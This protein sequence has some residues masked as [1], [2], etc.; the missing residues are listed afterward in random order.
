MI[1]LKLV[2][3]LLSLSII[4][5]SIKKPQISAAIYIIY[6]FLAP[7]MYINGF[8]IYERVGAIFFLTMFL[9][10]FSKKIAF[11]DYKPFIPFFFLLFCQLISVIFAE[12]IENSFSNWLFGVLNMCF[13]LFL[14]GNIKITP[15]Y[16][17]VYKWI[18]FFTMLLVTI[19]GL[20]LT[21][22]PGVNP[23]K[24]IEQPL[25]GQEFNEAY[26][27]GG[28]GNSTALIQTLRDGRLFGRISSFFD[29]PMTYGLHLGLFFIF[30]LYLFKNRIKI[31]I[32]ILLLIITAILTSGVR[33]PIAALLVTM[34]FV[35]LYMKK[36]SYFVFG[37]F[38]II[39]LLYIVPFISPEMGEYVSSIINSDNSEINGS[40]TTMRLEQL[41]GCWNI[42]QE[43]TQTLIMGKGL[44]WTVWYNAVKGSHP[45]ALYFESLIFVILVETGILG[46]VSWIIFT[47]KYYN[48]SIQFNDR[49]KKMS[50]LSLLVYFYV[51]C[52][53][54]G[55]FDIKNIFIY[56]VIIMFM[57]PL[58]KKA[59]QQ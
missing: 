41:E 53:I 52:V 35:V 3:T 18:L 45:T 50:I 8:I 59:F 36:M 2:L 4:G 17:H 39:I 12:K 7:Y 47:K 37:L 1:I 57:S 46:C 9:I 42:I 58:K 27:L 49:T 34:L 16:I 28:S 56:Y 31:L 22:M 14:Y 43:N 13:V 21:S 29:H 30:C 44:G 33:T 40:N 6:M 15:S 10:H 38:L 26:A 5:F 48:V 19:Y 25:F 54:T 24:M 51:Y 23:Y 32:P 11:T 20:F 55:D